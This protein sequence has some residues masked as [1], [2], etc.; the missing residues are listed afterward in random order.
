MTVQL[1]PYQSDLDGLVAAAWNAGH[2]NVVM[3]LPT[4]GGK[5]RILAAIVERHPGASCIIAHRSEIVAQLSMALAENGVRH[6]LIAAKKDKEAIAK[7]HVKAFGRSFFD[8]NS[9]CAVASVDTLIRKKD[10]EKWAATVTLWVT[11]EGHHLVLENKWNKAIALFTNPAVRGLLLTASPKRADGVGLGRPEIGGGGVAD[12]L[13]EGSSLRWLIDEGYLCDYRIITANSHIEELLGE[14]GSSGD[15]STAQLKAANEQSPIVGNVAETYRQLNAGDVRGVPAAP[16]GRTGILFASDIEIAKKFL[17]ELRK[18]GV[19]AELVTGETDPG[20]RRE[21]FKRLE[22]YDIELIVCVDIVSEGTDIP[23][24]ELGIFAR[25]TA[26]L[27]VYLQ[28]FG[29]VLRP[30]MTPEFRAARTREERLAAIAKSRKPIAYI[31]D[32]VGNFA[33]HGPPDRERVWDLVSTRGKRGHS[34]A[35]SFRNCL[36][37]NNP[38]DICGQPFERFRTECPYCGWEPPL[39]EGRSSPS[40]VSGDM[41]LLDPEILAALRGEADAA[42]M[43]VAD[44]RAKLTATGLP[45]AYIMKNVKQ[46]AAKIEGQ[47][48]LR[49]FMASWVGDRLRDGLRDREIHKLFFERF[50]VDVVSAQSLGP[51]EANAL[52]EKILFDG[53]VKLR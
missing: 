16:E 15:W 36:N 42:V 6:N 31:I 29:R 30:L 35:I 9:Q 21:T 43:S 40:V 48:A 26:S 1:R 39:P 2:R 3:V 23:S 44:Y 38:P 22:N 12:I 45:S 52:A 32:H 4:G 7:L 25:A 27:A 10:V 8:P 50:G 18:R 13:V 51:K 11:D 49:E 34:D 20:I 46:H 28:Q 33:R 47:T 24:L 37:V 14:V 53:A 41:V 5:T 19:R 17:L